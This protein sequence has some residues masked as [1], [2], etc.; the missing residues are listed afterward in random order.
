[1]KF[2]RGFI[3]AF[4]GIRT[5]FLSELNF[6]VHIIALATVV[7]LGIYFSISQLDWILITIVSSVVLSLEAINT[8]IEKVCDEISLE[9]K[10]SIRFIKDVAAGAVLIASIG[11]ALVGVI[12]FMKYISF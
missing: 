4:R 5:V 9:K 3:H 6:K 12:I 8:A 11:A 2:F 7:V 10:E 1:M